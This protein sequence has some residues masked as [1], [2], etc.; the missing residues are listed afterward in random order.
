MLFAEMKI[1]SYQVD[2]FTDK[3]FGGNPAVVALLEH[4]C[5]MSLKL[6]ARENAAPE[7]A[8]ILETESGYNLDGLLRILKWTFAVMR[9]AGIYGSYTFLLGNL[10][11]MRGCI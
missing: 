7:T 10:V 11:L 4:S 6:I 1:L 9:R 2:S 8:F 3:V 5:P